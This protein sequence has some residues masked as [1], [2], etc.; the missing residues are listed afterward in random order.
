VGGSPKTS[1]PPPGVYPRSSLILPMFFVENSL[2]FL[3]GPA[4]LGTPKPPRPWYPRTLLGTVS[5]VGVGRTPPP[6]LKKMPEGD[7][8]PIWTSVCEKCPRHTRFRFFFGEHSD[9]VST[10]PY[11]QRK[12]RASSAAFFH[13]AETEAPSLKEELTQIKQRGPRQLGVWQ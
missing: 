2:H 13:N 3:F 5:W 12:H 8:S 6:E 10:T 9:A 7:L 1:P 11:G 4:F